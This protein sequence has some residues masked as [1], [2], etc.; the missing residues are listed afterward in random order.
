MS[1][2]VRIDAAT[3][4]RCRAGAAVALFALCLH[5]AELR[6]QQPPTAAAATIATRS[7][8]VGGMKLQYL[9]AGTGPA[10]VLL[11]GYAETSRMWRPLIPALAQHFTVVAPD[12][13][14]IGDSAIPSEAPD[15]ESAAT[16]IHALVK[17]LGIDKAQV[18]GHDIGLMV[19]YSY[20]TQ[21]PAEVEKLVL[22]DAFLP[23]VGN[24]QEVYD[25]PALWH[26]R[27]SGPTPEALVKGRER[28]YFDY[29]WNSFAADATHSIP[30]ADR[31]A[32]AAAYARPGRMRAA[33]AYFASFPRVAASFAERAK[34]KLPMP[35]LTIGGERA[36][37]AVLAQEVTL[38]ASHGS[39]VI[40]AN[41]GHWLME[42]NRDGTSEALTRFLTTAP[43][44][45][46]AREL[47]LTPAEASARG[48]DSGQAGT[49]GLAGYGDR[50]DERAL[51]A[52]PAGSVY[53]EPAGLDH[54]ART[55]GEPAIVEISGFGPTDTQ[56]FAPG[57]ATAR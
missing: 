53:S 16:V 5:V 32:Y 41:T 8:V 37:G 23:G 30:E 52:L 28:T 20:A 21:F 36:N 4:R 26:F 27:F 29:Y 9:T 6:A 38:I 34:T 56:Y 57:T 44:A 39:S 11:H 3:R 46:A 50:F 2:T 25:S 51:K 33:W 35:V 54:F 40:L 17:S 19:A 7:A 31:Q 48:F 24:W 43:A 55:D 22:M 15:L 12:L 18:V 47:R 45:A 14:G 42:E 49:S 10:I 13:P 1:P